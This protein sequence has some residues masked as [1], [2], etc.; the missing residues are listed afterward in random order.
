MFWKFCKRLVARLNPVERLDVG[1]QGLDLYLTRWLIRLP[2]GR[3]LMLH[4]FH[5]GDNEEY[6]H[7]HP[8]P[9]WS[10]ILYGGYWEESECASSELMSSSV[11]ALPKTARRWFG[12]GSL[13]RRSATW[14]HKVILPPGKTC[15]TLVWTGR[16]QRS[17]G[18][19]PCGF[20]PWKEHQRRQDHGLPMCE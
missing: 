13:L 7:D 14:R 11:A 3:R 10:L 18:F 2:F 16:K 4:H 15:W 17:W 8:W 9:F 12:P 6:L 19:W 1:R 5:H 20:M